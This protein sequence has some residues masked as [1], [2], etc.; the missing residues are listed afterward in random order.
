MIFYLYRCKKTNRVVLNSVLENPTGFI[1][2]VEATNWGDARDM[3]S[4][5][6]Y[7][8]RAGYGYF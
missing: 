5:L 3:V 7:E 1:D 2:S 8:Y 4:E 6:A